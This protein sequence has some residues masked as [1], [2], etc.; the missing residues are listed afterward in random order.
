MKEKHTNKESH[1]NY[2]N[3]V[4]QTK[5]EQLESYNILNTIVPR[6][7]KTFYPYTDMTPEKILFTQKKISLL[8]KKYDKYNNTYKADKHKNL[9]KGGNTTTITFYG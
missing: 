5:Q 8:V 4:P 2:L 1:H 6:Y 7:L 9:K 3:Q